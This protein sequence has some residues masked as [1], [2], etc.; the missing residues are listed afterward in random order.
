ME[1]EV[2]NVK[3]KKAIRSQPVGHLVLRPWSQLCD[4]ST[5]RPG[6]TPDPN[7]PQTDSWEI[8][9]RVANIIDYIK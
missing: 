2:N 7:K 1:E 4:D 3:K 5:H 9:E 6:V 8:K